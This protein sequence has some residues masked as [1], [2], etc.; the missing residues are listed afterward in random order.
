MARPRRV[1]SDTSAPYA[2][3]HHWEQ[4]KTSSANILRSNP[5]QSSRGARSFFASAL[6]AASD[7]GLA[8]C[9]FGSAPRLGDPTSWFPDCSLPARATPRP[10]LYTVAEHAGP[11]GTLMTSQDR[12]VRF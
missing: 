12:W 4:A 11:T 7:D 6:A 5:V 3:R 10:D 9:G 8:S 1:P 2:C